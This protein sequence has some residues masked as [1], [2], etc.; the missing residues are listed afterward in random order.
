MMMLAARV[1]GTPESQVQAV[2][3]ALLAIDPQQPVYHVKPLAQMVSESPPA[4][5]A[6]RSR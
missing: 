4:S 5:S 6:R 3:G 2:R 1:S